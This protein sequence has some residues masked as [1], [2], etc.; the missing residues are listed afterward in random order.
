MQKAEHVR[1][2]SDQT[3]CDGRTQFSSDGSVTNVISLVSQCALLMGI[4]VHC[5]AVYHLHFAFNAW[6]D[7]IVTPVVGKAEHC[8]RGFEQKVSLPFRFTE[9]Q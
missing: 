4:T 7:Q 6:H 8:M 5:P 2:N 9:R 1:V 3:L